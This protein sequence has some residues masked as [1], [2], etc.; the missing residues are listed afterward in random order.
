MLSGMAKEDV[1]FCFLKGAGHSEAKEI[2]EDGHERM[3]AAENWG[4]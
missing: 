3:R 4:T 1:I 2:R